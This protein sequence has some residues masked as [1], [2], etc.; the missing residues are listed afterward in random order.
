MADV[1]FSENA[2]PSRPPL[3]RRVA[4]STGFALLMYAGLMGLIVYG[5]YSG[6]ARMGYNWQWYNIPRY[7][8]RFTDN[9]FQAGELIVGLGMTLF[10]SLG[11]FLLAVAIGLAMALLRLSN[12]VIG[13]WLS[14][15][16][17]EFLRNMPLLVLVYLFYYVLGPIFTWS[18]IMAAVVCLGAFHGA[19][20][21]EIIRGGVKSVA[22]GQWEAAKS[23]GMTKGQAYR[24]IILPQAVPLMLPPLTNEAI[25]LVKSSA[26][27]SVIAVAELTTVG[28]N[29]V[30]DTY[31]SFEIWFTVALIYLA[32]TLTMSF[33]VS[34]LESRI[35]RHE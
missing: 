12:L 5:A 26:I 18:R 28:R 20:V 1:T 25:Q 6:A 33:G 11:A 31:M 29:L 32:I 10:L 7:I 27:V 22:Q 23:I 13:K 19:L 30:S 34:A 14:I 2:M 21:S 15:A 4:G 3:S 16:L 9:G 24:Y 8:Y 35:G 17:L